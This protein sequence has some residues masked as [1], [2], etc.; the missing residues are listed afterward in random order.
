MDEV[1]R[2]V[3]HITREGQCIH[4]SNKKYKSDSTSSS[5]SESDS[6]SDS[7]SSDS[8]S[9]MKEDFIKMKSSSHSKKKHAGITQKD[10]SSST[11]YAAITSNSKQE[12]SEIDGLIKQFREMKILLAEAVTKVSR[13]EQRKNKH[14][15]H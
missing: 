3:I 6:D 9:P 14:K 4:T 12:S 2:T 13:L 7:S 15:L 10:K 11:S 1:E 5:C 8:N